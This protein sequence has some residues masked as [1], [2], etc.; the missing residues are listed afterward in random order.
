MLN[1]AGTANVWSWDGGI[2]DATNFL[3]PSGTTTFT[4]TGTVDST[5]CETTDMVD[6]AEVII[7]VTITSTGANLV[8]NQ[9]GGTYQ[10]LACPA[11][12]P[13]TG[14]TA[15]TFAAVPEGNYAVEITLDGCVDTSACQEVH[16][17]VD[18]L[19]ELGLNIYPIPAADNLTLELAEGNG[20]FT[21][22]SVSGELLSTRQIT[23]GKT[24]VDL[25]AYSNGMYIISFENE[26]GIHTTQLIIE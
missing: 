10:W 23:E 7:D 21:L 24:T 15:Q 2:V 11:L 9:A 17:G 19:I 20:T 26:T 25:S 16:L 5:G 3:P 8:S 12:T 22:Y 13:V 18:N 4:L 14:E 6:V 1:A